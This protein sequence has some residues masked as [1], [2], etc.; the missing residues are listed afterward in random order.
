[1]RNN[2]MSNRENFVRL[3]ESRTEKALK[4]IKIIGN[5]TN[6]TNY[7]Y[8]EKD[9]NEIFNTLNEEIKATRNRFKS[10]GT[11]KEKAKFKLSQTSK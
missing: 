8:T 3:A 9:V 1:M 5:L 2:I 4:A 6:P 10:S 11:S 7:S